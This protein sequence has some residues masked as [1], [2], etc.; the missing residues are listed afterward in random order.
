MLFI[1]VTLFISD[2]S[3]NVGFK[4]KKAVINFDWITM[5]FKNEAFKFHK[6][7]TVC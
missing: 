7:K 2:V 3:D 6:N 4:L 5:E 1:R